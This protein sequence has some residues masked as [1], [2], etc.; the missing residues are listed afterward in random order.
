MRGKIISERYRRL[1]EEARRAA[2]STTDVIEKAK[3]EFLAAHYAARSRVLAEES[4]K[5]RAAPRRYRARRQDS[6]A[7]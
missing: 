1:E 5:M 2:A 4:R 3:H 7:A 6:S